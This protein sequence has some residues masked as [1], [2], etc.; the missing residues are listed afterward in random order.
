MKN[1]HAIAF[2]LCI[3]AASAVSLASETSYVW[4][5]SDRTTQF[6]AATVGYSAEPENKV[7]SVVLSASVS[8]R[9]P[10]VVF[11]GGNA[12]EFAAG[13]TV[14]IGPNA[15]LRF[16]TPVS[17]GGISLTD[18]YNGT[19]STNAFDN[20]LYDATTSVLVF[21]GMS[22]SEVE[23]ESVWLWSGAIPSV[24]VHDG[25]NIVRTATTLSA[26]F[27]V[28][29]GPHAKGVRVTLSDAED[30]I[31]ACVNYARYL[32]NAS[33]AYEMSFD[34]LAALKA[35]GGNSVS[36][37]RDSVSNT[38][39]GV[40]AVTVNS[41]AAIGR[42]TMAVAGSEYSLESVSVAPGA[43]L[44]LDGLAEGSSIT[45]V[46]LDRD[47][48]LKVRNMAH[49]AIVGR[50]SGSGGRIAFGCD[51]IESSSVVVVTNV[52]PSLAGKEKE[53]LVA[54]ATSLS[55]I[56]GWSVP[57]IVNAVTAPSTP[58]ICFVTTNAEDRTIQ[59]Q[60]Q[61]A[62]GATNVKGCALEFSETAGRLF[63]RKLLAAYWLASDAGPGEVD[64]L[65]PGDVAFKGSWT[66][67]GYYN[68]SSIRLEYVAD[69]AI[70]A[71]A[72]AVSLDNS[73]ARMVLPSARTD[74]VDGI[75]V[76][77]LE[78]NMSDT[79][80]EPV[81]CF[82][83]RIGSTIEFELQIYDGNRTKGSKYRMFQDGDDVY[84][85]KV[86]S[87]YTD[88]RNWV[89][90][91]SFDDYDPSEY[92]GTSTG[93]SYHMT[94]MT[95]SFRRRRTMTAYLPAIAPKSVTNLAIDV[96]ADVALAVGGGT[97]LPEQGVVTVSGMLAVTN[98]QAIGS[99]RL[100]VLPGGRL[101]LER[102][103]A[104][105][106]DT[107]RAF[108][109]DGGELMLMD[110]LS[111]MNTPTFKNG[112]TVTKGG[113]SGE[114]RVGAK[115]IKWVVGG[116][117]CSTCSVPI[118][119]V[120]APNGGGEYTMEWNVADATGDDGVDFWMNAGMT[121]FADGIVGNINRNGGMIHKKTG[122]GTL[123]WGGLSTCTGIVQVVEGTLLL[124]ASNAL[125]PGTSANVQLRAKQPVQLMGGTLAAEPYVTN[126]V[127]YVSVSTNASAIALGEGSSLSAD[128]FAGFGVGG[129]LNVTLGEGATLHFDTTLTADEL[130]RIRVNGRN[131]ALQDGNG[132]IVSGGIP[133]V[134]I[135]IR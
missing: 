41:Y 122:A 71:A 127:Q 59:F 8:D 90:L 36:I 2:G 51:P 32:R 53:L 65:H 23:I 43:M 109:F 22:V 44:V 19:S 132:D 57:S 96:G 21:P 78:G 107:N 91:K 3:F 16:E 126:T 102:S 64:I 50:L 77:H 42:P 100:T 123:R 13:A 130:R 113:N 18:A 111:Y 79:T 66:G 80:K 92:V 89:G 20:W 95:V 118:R 63:V 97:A 84:C 5:P 15:N 9:E 73:T 104:V 47:A 37:V 39:Y 52:V 29:D 93:A 4:T 135:F 103:N 17:G 48:E 117:S 112:A 81:Y 105:A 68:P 83:R 115:N 74:S 62:D 125:N 45:N 27:Q 10:T 46:S 31:H 134:M 12:F 106:N 108:T 110:D 120:S 60:V 131:R 128:A 101:S 67:K 76:G 121:E 61:A 119:C 7:E 98:A 14:G 35:A 69:T 124:G 70:T 129:K 94:G 40:R 25:T 87:W 49:A 58:V 28:M 75:Y 34:D 72:V 88:S 85:S 116:E 6:G 1:R 54:D 86:I 82:E 38:G 26:E 55:D 114:M 11:T 30:G 56:V 33:R 24:V 99:G 133:G